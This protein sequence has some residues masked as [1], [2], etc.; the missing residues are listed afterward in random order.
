MK[1]TLKNE[2]STDGTISVNSVELEAFAMENSDSDAKR[3][4]FPRFRVSV[5]GEILEF[6]SKRALRK[7][8]SVVACPVSVEAFRNAGHGVT[9]NF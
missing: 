2:R 5:D 9:I 8:L 7:L 1:F 4:G 3:D 6:N